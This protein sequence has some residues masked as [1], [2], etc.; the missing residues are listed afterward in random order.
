[1]RFHLRKQ[2]GDL[3]PHHEIVPARRPAFIQ[4]VGTDISC[5]LNDDPLRVVR[6]KIVTR[7]WLWQ[8]RGRLNA[9]FQQ[10]QLA[11]HVGEYKANMKQ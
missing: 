11:D 3:K 2:V 6:S 1:L 10:Q 4:E 5:N 9:D 8:L 7:R